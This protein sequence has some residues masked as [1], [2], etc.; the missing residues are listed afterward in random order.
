MAYTNGIGVVKCVE[1]GIQSGFDDI[2]R[3]LARVEHSVLGLK[4]DEIDAATELAEHRRAPDQLESIIRELRARRE[5]RH[6][7][8][9]TKRTGTESQGKFAADVD[10]PLPYEI[11]Q[12]GTCSR[13]TACRG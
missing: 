2:R 1:K 3:R 9:G 11:G 10:S 5:R 7:G 8:T 4:R 13:S 6:E 12:A